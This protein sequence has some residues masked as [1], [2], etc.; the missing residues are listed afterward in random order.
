[1][2]DLQFTEYKMTELPE[3]SPLDPG[4]S[5]WDSPQHLPSCQRIKTAFR[6]GSKCD[7]KTPDWKK[8]ARKRGPV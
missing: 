2:P 4:Y 6:V 1:M 3:P 8:V 7:C 5:H